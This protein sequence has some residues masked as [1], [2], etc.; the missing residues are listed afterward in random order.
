[1]QCDDMQSLHWGY[2]LFKNILLQGL[3]PS[4]SSE[5]VTDLAISSVFLSQ[6]WLIY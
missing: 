1:M 3:L 4:K 5:V 6:E 2:A